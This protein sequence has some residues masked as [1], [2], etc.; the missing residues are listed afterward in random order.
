[1]AR[2]ALSRDHDY[3]MGR[4]SRLEPIRRHPSAGGRVEYDTG[5]RRR[6]GYPQWAIDQTRL[7]S[8]IGPI[9]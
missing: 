2:V 9:R 8:L 5:C 4:V 3:G 6:G 1:M 7:V